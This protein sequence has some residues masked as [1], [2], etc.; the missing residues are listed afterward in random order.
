MPITI[1]RIE[2]QKRKNNRYSLFAGAEFIISVNDKT[3]LEFGI[4]T[5]Q[6]L[7]EEIIVKIKK[8]ESYY[9][10]YEQALRYLARRAHAKYELGKKLTQ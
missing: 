9:L 10:L 8:K 1:T 4:H 2:P 5:G 3:L 7:S 6:K